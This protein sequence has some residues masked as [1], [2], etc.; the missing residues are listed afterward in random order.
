MIA[1]DFSYYANEIPGFFY[2]MGIVP[3][4][5]EGPIEPIHSPRFY[6]D[7]Q[8]LKIAVKTMSLLALEALFQY[9]EVSKGK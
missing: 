8:A 1:E 6:V 3:K 4:G 7:E 5:Y 2:F 9:E